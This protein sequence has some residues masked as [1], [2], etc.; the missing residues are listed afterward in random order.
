MEN[1][2]NNQI[3]NQ[4]LLILKNIKK[5]FGNVNALKGVYLRAFNG[6]VMGI[7]GENGAGKSTL[8]NVLS[9]VI[10]K[11]SGELI[12]NNKTL[13][14]FKN[15]KE[16]ER[17]GISIIHQEIAC[18]NDMNVLDNIY[19]GHEISCL[20]F[21]NYSK[22]RKKV[23]EI[24]KL[25]RLEIDLGSMMNSLTIAEQQMVEIAK[26][27]LRKSKLIIFDEPTSSLSKSEAE[28]L[29]EVIQKLK[30]EDIAICY[31]SHKLEEIPI[32]CDFITIIRDGNFIGEYTVNELNE[33]E[34]ISKMVGREINEKYPLK[35]HIDNKEIILEV[36]ELSNS[37]VKNINFKLYKNE[38]LGFSGLV[39]AQ[40]TELFKSL[41]GFYPIT[42]GKVLLNNKQVYLKS[43]GSSI[44]KGIYYVTED[45]KNDGLLL[46]ESIRKNISLS[47][48]DK[49]SRF[50]F[51]DFSKE[52][53]L[54]RNYI[55]KMSIKTLSPETFVGTMSGGNQ[56]K[57]LLAKAFAAEPKIMIFDEPTRGVDVGSRRE[58]YDLIYEAKRNG[59]GVIVIS[60]DLPEVIGLCNRVMVMKSGKITNIINGDSLSPD[61][62][63]KYSI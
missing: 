10:Q 23:K 51:I 40:R 30:K 6:K 13:N 44:K 9:G 43:V 42:T 54:A 25:L 38:I 2:F 59:I 5:N 18:F 31:I 11:S 22:Q 12:W 7:L 48:L 3:K 26:A 52:K 34:I 45:R 29:F 33:D 57:V 21:I 56:Q 4:P 49:I 28:V 32:I 1:I 41:I 35:D 15:V 46:N 37:F 58:I 19:A 50:G 20:G 62:I 61:E 8:M 16:A 14:N 39:G 36:E 47:S 27:I 60:S 24:F 53:K 63:M 55:K 17:I